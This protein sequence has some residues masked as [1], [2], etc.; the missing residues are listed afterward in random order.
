MAISAVST[1]DCFSAYVEEKP[2]TKT[3]YASEITSPKELVIRLS[4]NMVSQPAVISDSDSLDE[5]VEGYSV[6]LNGELLGNVSEKGKAK[7]EKFVEEKISEYKS[8]IK[9]AKT[10]L[11]DKIEYAEGTFDSLAVGTSEE[12]IAQMELSVKTVYK[13]SVTE[14]IPFETVTEKSN[15]VFEGCE[16]VSVE[17]RDGEL[18]TVFQITEINGKKTA[19]KAV[20]TEVIAE[21]V[22]KVILEGTRKPAA[23]S[24]DAVA[25]AEGFIFPLGKASCYVSSDFGY[26]SFD[27]DFH[28]GID[29]AAD[30]GTE[31]YSSACGTVIFAGWDDTG[32]GNYV[33]VDHGN[34]Y[35][36]GYAHLSS[37]SV[38]KGDSVSAGQL[39][40]G[41]GS[42]GYSTGNH[43]HFIVKYNDEY[44]DPSEVL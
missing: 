16:A 27:G 21:P 13:V 41:V 4:S 23:L 24:A 14:A 18:K 33:L 19:E 17:G 34:G 5:T 25:K 26:R 9:G 3:P 40:G 42:T 10:A 30:M 20:E 43:L 2:Q 36:T 31:V 44:V 8:E 22:N 11:S 38:S 1:L 6:Y 37:I 28:N 12:I 35:K 7:V 39:V 29:Y 32:F 15:K